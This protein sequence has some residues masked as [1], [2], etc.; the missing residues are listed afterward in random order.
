MTV[1]IVGHCCVFKS[2]VK[3]PVDDI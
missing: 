2:K 3:G 1:V